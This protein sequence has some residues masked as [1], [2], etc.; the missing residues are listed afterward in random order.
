MAVHNVLFIYLLVL[1]QFKSHFYYALYPNTLRW[2]ELSLKA[3]TVTERDTWNTEQH[4]EYSPLD[5][6]FAFFL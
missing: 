1:I 4:L 3:D 5:L 6:M 2:I